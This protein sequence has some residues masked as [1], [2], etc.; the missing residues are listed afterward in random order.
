MSFINLT[1][2]FSVDICRKVSIGIEPLDEP[3]EHLADQPEVGLTEVLQGDQ[4]RVPE[5]PHHLSQTPQITER[6]A[7][8]CR[9]TRSPKLYKVKLI[10]VDSVYVAVTNITV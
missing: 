10:K 6:H 8:A 3:A 1:Y 9:G 2:L 4:P 7:G 5:C